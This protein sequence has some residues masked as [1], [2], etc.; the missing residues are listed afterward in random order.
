MPTAAKLV[1]SVLFAAL[2]VFVA[3]LYRQGIT[4]GTR[5]AYLVPGCAAIGLICGWRVMGRLVGTGMGDA[6]GSG[7][8]TSLTIVFFALLFFSIY[9]MVLTSTKG[10]YDGPMQAVLAIF[11]IMLDYGRGLITPEVLGAIFVGGGLAGM[12]AEWA[13]RR[14]P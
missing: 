1:A 8:R 10:L 13:D 3:D 7:I 9:E 4:D 14:W 6:L 5:T 12:G 2:A 11:D